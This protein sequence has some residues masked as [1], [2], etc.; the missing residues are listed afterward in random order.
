MTGKLA[1]PAES[2]L[3]LQSGVRSPGERE[4]VGDFG[5]GDAFP[6]C[7]G[8]PRRDCPTGELVPRCPSGQGSRPAF[9]K[10]DEPTV[11]SQPMWALNPDDGIR[12]RSGIQG[13]HF[14][15]YTGQ[16][17]EPCVAVYE[18]VGASRFVAVCGASAALGLLPRPLATPSG[19][20]WGDPTSLMN[21]P[22]PRGRAPVVSHTMAGNSIPLETPRDRAAH[23]MGRDLHECDSDHSIVFPHF[24]SRR[25]AALGPWRLGASRDDHSST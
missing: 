17:G 25:A 13:L 8:D 23:L 10:G 20:K 21:A 1:P 15:S 22:P 2:R 11:E 4:G 9:D 5:A 14:R 19:R 3:G 6:A 12:G 24:G 16:L 18:R 7:E